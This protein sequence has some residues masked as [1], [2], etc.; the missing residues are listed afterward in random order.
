[1]RFDPAYTV[2]LVDL[3]RPVE[4]ADDVT[5]G[6][7][8]ESLERM[9]PGERAAL[10]A[11]LG[12]PLQSWLDDCLRPVPDDRASDDGA[13]EASLV[14]IQLAWRCVCWGAQAIGGRSPTGVSLDVSGIG[15]LWP[16]CRPGGPGYREEAPERRD[17]A[18][19]FTPLARLRHLPLR[20][21][22]VMAVQVAGPSAAGPETVASLPAPEMT[23]LDLLAGLFDEFTRE[24]SPKAREHEWAELLRED[25]EPREGITLQQYLAEREARRRGSA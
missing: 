24:G 22:P 15:D 21:D 7:L 13:S 3:R 6:A 16:S 17:Y 8:C 18:L 11:V 20:L 12:Y 19:N 25:D 2:A 1:V 23:L 10:E 4:L 14:A 5:L 9:A